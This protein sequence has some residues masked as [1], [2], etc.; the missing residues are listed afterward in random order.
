MSPSSILDTNQNFFGF[1]VR[2]LTGHNIPLV[3]KIRTADIS[4]R[5]DNTVILGIDGYWHAR[6][7]SY[8]PPY[9]LGTVPKLLKSRLLLLSKLVTKPN[10]PQSIAIRHL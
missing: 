1:C 7:N 6:R 3:N 5:G 10:L 4:Y 2:I 8:L 9:Y